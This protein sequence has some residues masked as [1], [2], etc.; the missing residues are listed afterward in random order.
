MDFSPADISIAVGDVVEWVWVSG[1]HNV[2]GSQ[3]TYPNN[4]ESFQSE[5]GSDLTFSH[6]FNVA[7][8]YD[9]QC[10]PHAD[11]GMVGTITVGMSGC[12]DPSACNY[13]ENAEFSDGSCLES[14]CAGEQPSE[15]TVKESMTFFPVNRSNPVLS[16]QESSRSGT[17]SKSVSAKSK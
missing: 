6:T 1:F 7:G 12:T 10:D 3:E 16:G 5:L 9:Y 11:M 14:D 15:S 4:P 8:A 2:N 17:P 13:D